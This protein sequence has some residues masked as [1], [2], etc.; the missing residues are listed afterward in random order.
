MAKPGEFLVQFAPTLFLAVFFIATGR[1]AAFAASAT[2]WQKTLE[3]AKKE[4]RVVVSI[5][6]SAELRKG[7]EEA[8][9]PK[10]GV[11]L[12]LIVAR[13]S[14]SVRKIA[15]EYKAGVRYVDVHIGGTSSAVQGLLNENVLDPVDPYF[16]LPEVKD[17]KNWW[18]GHMWIDKAGKFIYG[19]QAY[20]FANVWYNPTLLKPEDIRSYD[21]LLDPKWKGKIGILDPRTPGAGDATWSFL[22]MVKG[23]DYLKKLAAQDLLLENNQRQLAEAMVK[24]KIVLTL[25]L[26]EYTFQP[27]VKAGLP[28]KPLP[29]PSEG[30][31]TTGGSG[32]LVVIK[33]PPHP[34]ATK[35]FVN[36]LLSREGQEVFTRSMGQATRRLDVDT[37]SLAESGVLA[38][39]DIMTPER[40]LAL[41][42]Q[43]EE[44]IYQVRRPASK[45]A[46][47][48]FR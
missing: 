47:N 4:G 10:Y 32:N 20:T 14:P 34:N 12:E 13:G 35:V 38:A 27:F 29:T 22:L 26:T 40:F 43:S 48:L 36:W 24:G 25:G 17:P 16:I 7:M 37:K 42:N 19:F 44:R 9:Q 39:K 33:D 3:A 15:D 31:Y 11:K 28:A 46:K 1:E 30:S 21:D 6:A 45:I 41:E 5:P 18:G 2:D 8:F 23:E